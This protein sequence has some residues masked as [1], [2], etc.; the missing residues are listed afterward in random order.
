MFMVG[1]TMGQHLSMI[2]QG[3]RLP[4]P[5]NVYI[6]KIIFFFKKISLEVEP[7]VEM[8]DEWPTL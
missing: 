6:S 5:K 1:E 3:P 2:F 8:I 7:M 4:K